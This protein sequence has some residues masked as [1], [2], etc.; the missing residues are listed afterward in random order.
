M[1]VSSMWIGISS[2]GAGGRVEVKVKETSTMG[3]I[4]SFDGLAFIDGRKVME[5]KLTVM[6]ATDEQIE[7][8]KKGIGL[9]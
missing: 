4:Y 1:S 6:N 3:M 7:A 5:G 9:V 2:F 8:M